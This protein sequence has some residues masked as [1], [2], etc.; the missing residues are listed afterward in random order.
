MP[1][2]V[3]LQ[4]FRYGPNVTVFLY[5]SLVW[6]SELQPEFLMKVIFTYANKEK[7]GALFTT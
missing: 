6:F 3:Q 5:A 7:K 2:L 4:P 1:K